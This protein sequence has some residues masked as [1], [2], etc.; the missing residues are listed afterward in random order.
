MGNSRNTSVVQHSTKTMHVMSKPEV[1]NGATQTRQNFKQ[2]YRN[3][4]IK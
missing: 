1:S 3:Y 2:M 4:K